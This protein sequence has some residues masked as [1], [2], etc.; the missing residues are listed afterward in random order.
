MGI[1]AE[2]VHAGGSLAHATDFWKAGE[3]PLLMGPFSF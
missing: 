1:F 2:V 3:H